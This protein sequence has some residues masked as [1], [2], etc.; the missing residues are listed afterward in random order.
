M[1]HSGNGSKKNFSESLQRRLGSAGY[2][3]ISLASSSTAQ[4][5]NVALLGKKR[6]E[7]IIVPDDASEATMKQML[8]KTTE[9]QKMLPESSI[10]LLG[11]TLGCQAPRA[12]T[13]I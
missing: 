2:D 4:Q 1:L 3:V 12:P 6:G 10:S 8:A 11:L 9:L 13:A 7:Y 5:I